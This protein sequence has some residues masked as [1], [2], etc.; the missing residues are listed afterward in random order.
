M[1]SSELRVDRDHEGPMVELEYWRHLNIK[2][3][4]ILEEIR[5]HEC[6]MAIQILN[7]TKSRVLK[8]K[9]YLL[10]SFGPLFKL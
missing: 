8:V 6:R 2:Y 10:L 4:S 9:A 3:N 5:G 1:S 7:I